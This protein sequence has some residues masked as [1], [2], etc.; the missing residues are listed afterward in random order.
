MRSAAFA[1]CF[2]LLAASG[3]A[4]VY[5]CADSA[6]RDRFSD[7][8]SVCA[9]ATVAP[10][11][12]VI[13]AP[14]AAG[15]PAAPG[16]EGIAGSSGV[17]DLERFFAP[18]GDGWKIVREAPEVPDPALRKGGLRASLARHYT[19]TRG[20]VSE[21]C[22]I[23]LWAFDRAAQAVWVAASLAQPGW[24]ILRAG[25]ILVLL[26]SVRL[27][28]R[29]GTLWGVVEGCEELGERARARAAAKS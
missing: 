21:V 22:T 2:V 14:S 1:A 13:R 28:R 8:P 4:E 15:G 12:E 5:R 20:P 7:D 29:V 10:H 25:A 17:P 27:E 3:R 9:E 23:E 6:G 24:K 16:G 26:H 11:R 18:A 19:R